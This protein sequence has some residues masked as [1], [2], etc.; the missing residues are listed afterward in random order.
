MQSIF[1][2]SSCGAASSNSCRFSLGY[3]GGVKRKHDPLVNTEN[4]GN[5]VGSYTHQSAMMC[6]HRPLEMCVCFDVWC[7]AKGG[8]VFFFLAADA[9]AVHMRITLN[10]WGNI[11]E[12]E[13]SCGQPSIRLSPQWWP[14]D[15]ITDGKRK[16]RF[17]C[18]ETHSAPCWWKHCVL[19]II[20]VATDPLI[21]ATA[22]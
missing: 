1:V 19:F 16:C 22:C 11:F 18:R 12:Q 6:L 3:I 8:N 20:T 21:P 9:I 15:E 2:N 10:F 7:F 17:I 14:S 13:V 4:S 5:R